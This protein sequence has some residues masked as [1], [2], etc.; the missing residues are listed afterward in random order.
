MKLRELLAGV[1]LVELAADLETVNVNTDPTAEP[2]AEPKTAENTQ[3]NSKI[4]TNQDIKE[5]ISKWDLNAPKQTLI[6]NKIDGEELEKLNEHFKF[7]GNYP[8]TR[9]IDSEH[10]KHALNHH[11]D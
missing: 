7:K 3:G 11:G 1:P 8:L 6:T 9:Q 5:Q 2:T 10:I 4:L